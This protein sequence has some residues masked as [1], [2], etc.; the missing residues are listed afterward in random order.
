MRRFL[1]ALFTVTAMAIMPTA[2]AQA[3][4]AITCKPT[5]QA[6]WKS[7]EALKAQLTKQG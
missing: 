2:P 3:T 7:Q 1:P 5:P 6:S 4:G